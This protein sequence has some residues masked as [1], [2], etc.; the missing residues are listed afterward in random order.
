MQDVTINLPTLIRA[1]TEIVLG[2]VSVFVGLRFIL[3][4]FGASTSAP[5]VDWVYSTSAPLLTPFEGMFPTPE[6]AN[7]FVIEFSALFALII[8]ML[9]AYLIQV[10]VEEL[11]SSVKPRPRES[12]A[13][14][15]PS[16]AHKKSQPE[17]VKYDDSPVESVDTSHSRSHSSSFEE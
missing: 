5:F 8:Y 13:D 10:T 14:T 17:T 3:K 16:N 7:G 9:L 1:F 15:S 6:V 2:L 12:S 4:L 11:S